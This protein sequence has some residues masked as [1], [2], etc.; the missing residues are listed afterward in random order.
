MDISGEIQL[1]KTMTVSLMERLN[2]ATFE[3]LETFVEERQAVVDDL[4]RH[5]S[6]TSATD[7][8]KIEIAGILEND[9]AIQARMNALRLEAQDFLYKRGQAKTQRNAYE[10]GYA[11]D[12]ILMDRRK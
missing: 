6:T 9:G 8:Q 11:A 10:A 7:A 1:F 12:S 4:V 3:E 2:D 5:L